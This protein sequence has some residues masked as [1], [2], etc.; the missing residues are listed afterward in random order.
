MITGLRDGCHY[1]DMDSVS[2]VLVCDSV[3]LALTDCPQDR[4][5]LKEETFLDVAICYERYMQ[6]CSGELNLLAMSWV[7]AAT[8]AESH[9]RG[10]PLLTDALSVRVVMVKQLGW[11]VQL[12]SILC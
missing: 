4:G 7:A 1:E 2:G 5:S 3:T 11:T 12:S 8:G 9:D 6:G 10:R